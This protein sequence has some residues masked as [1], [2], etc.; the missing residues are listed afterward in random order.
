MLQLTEEQ[1]I[2]KRVRFF[3]ISLCGEGY[4]GVRQTWNDWET[5]GIGLMM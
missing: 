5:S 1:V 2:S 3:L 4:M